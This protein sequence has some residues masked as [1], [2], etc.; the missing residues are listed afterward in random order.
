[1]ALPF[2]AAGIGA[3][4]QG[5]LAYKAAQDEQDAIKKQRKQMQSVISDLSALGRRTRATTTSRLGDISA[6]NLMSRDPQQRQQFAQAYT[7]T[8]EQGERAQANIAG[9][10]AQIKLQQPV[11]KRDKDLWMD[12]L[13]QG[14]LGAVSGFQLGTKLG[15]QADTEAFRTQQRDYFREQM[16]ISAP[17]P[18]VL[19]RA[20]TAVGKGIGFAGDW[21][22]SYFS[23]NKNIPSAPVSSRGVSPQTIA[24][25]YYG[26]GVY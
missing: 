21:L 11:Q 16:G 7:R 14:A 13:G 23:S 1:M 9:Q 3:L 15:Q 12:V 22:G 2:I 6:Q 4:V 8:A 18:S 25:Q 5:G 19:E 20:G 10:Q 17:P 26:Q 24:G